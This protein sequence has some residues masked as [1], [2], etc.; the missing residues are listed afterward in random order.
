MG[1]GTLSRQ[2]PAVACPSGTRCRAVGSYPNGS[3]QTLNEALRFNGRK[4]SRMSTPDRGGKT[5]LE[6]DQ[7]SGIACTASNSCWAVGAFSGNSGGLLN[8]ALRFNGKSWS[9][10]R[11]PDPGGNTAHHQ[12][13]AISCVSSKD[14][15][16]V[17]NQ[18]PATSTVASNEML[19]WNGRK[20]KAG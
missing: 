3:G 7:L 14:C 9:F 20:W 11:T 19:H 18:S 12:L 15:W 4:W 1:L 17:G 8:Q 16:A 6:M 13:E 10:A 2:L 5:T